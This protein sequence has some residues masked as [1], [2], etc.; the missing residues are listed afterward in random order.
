MWTTAKI[1]SR[2]NR[3]AKTWVN[4]NKDFAYC[5]WTHAELETFVAD[6]YPWLLSTY[7][8]YTYLIQRCDVARYMFLYHYGGV[9][10]DLDVVCHTPLA[11]MFDDASPSAGIILTP[12]VPLGIATDFIA[13]RQPRDPVLLGVL[14]GLRR[15]A[16]SWL[17]F[18]LPY[19]S[20]MFRTGPV[21][22]TRRIYCHDHRE[23]IFVLPSSK[24]RKYI[25]YV[26]GASWHNWDGWIIWNLFLL[27]HY[28]LFATGV[29]FILFF[30]IR[31]SIVRYFKNQLRARIRTG[32]SS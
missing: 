19:T 31:C 8:D 12:A 16:A 15:A 10:V 14:S 24:N 27:R 26:G 3:S 11:T 29:F 28:L 30:C 4:K 21:Y 7:H 32:I 13:V 9:Y 5:L 2:W 18:P 20:V 1:P 6:E 25:G 22:F 17:Y 23:N